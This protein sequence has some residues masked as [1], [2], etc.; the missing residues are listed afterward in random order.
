MSQQVIVDRD[1]L[2]R[3]AALY[4][5]NVKGP[6]MTEYKI[7]DETF[8]AD[9][10][11]NDWTETANGVT[12]AHAAL[13]GGATT[14]T[15]GGTLSDCAE[16]SNTAQWSA[17]SACGVEIKMKISQITD[18]CVCGG[19]IDVITNTDNRVAM[20]FN[21]T[22]LKALTNT[23]DV[24]GFLFD[25]DRTSA[26]YWYVAS[27]NGGVVGTPI[28]TNGSLAPVAGTYFKIRVQTDT[29]G[30][31][32]FYYNGIP[33]GYLPTAIAYGAGDLLTPYVGFIARSTVAQVC[34]ISR[35]TTWQTN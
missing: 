1:L 30:N 5:P 27:A 17:A 34:T 21:G 9:A 8:F 29:L 31:V 16:I 25:T 24:C 6:M 35:I 20:E 26:D 28:V 10:D 22:A 2:F 7:F 3:G 15:A 32:T 11:E 19:F 12:V 13:D 33:V 14:L 23:A 4:Q 18:V